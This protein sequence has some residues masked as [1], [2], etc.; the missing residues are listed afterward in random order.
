LLPAGVAAALAA[1]QD[2]EAAATAE[3]VARL[4]AARAAEANDPARQPQTPQ[5]GTPARLRNSLKR[6]RIDNASG[7]DES[8]SD[9]STEGG[10]FA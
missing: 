7:D 5:A 4:T 9:P 8:S 3:A 1:E 6:R 10:R 2:A